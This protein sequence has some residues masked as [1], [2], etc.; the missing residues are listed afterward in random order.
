[1]PSYQFYPNMQHGEMGQR[2]AKLQN[3][4][5]AL[6][7]SVTTSVQG[8]VSLEAMLNPRE[9][10]ADG[11]LGSGEIVGTSLGTKAQS[12]S[13]DFPNSIVRLALGRERTVQEARWNGHRD[14]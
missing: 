6:I 5:R 12:M 10:S 13:T 2:Q 7:T 4:G 3:M 14:H 8:V 11:R 1:M 9:H